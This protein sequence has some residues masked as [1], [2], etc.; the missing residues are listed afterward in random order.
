MKS[1]MTKETKTTTSSMNKSLKQNIK[2][3]DK[4]YDITQSKTY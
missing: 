3:P 1:H 4:S 2:V